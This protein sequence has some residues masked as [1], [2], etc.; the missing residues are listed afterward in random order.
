MMVIVGENS[1]LPIP[2]YNT[3]VMRNATKESVNVSN[4]RV[5]LAPPNC[6]KNKMG[7]L[8]QILQVR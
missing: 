3:C 5:D 8:L 2:L 4:L 6:T 1:A 7:R